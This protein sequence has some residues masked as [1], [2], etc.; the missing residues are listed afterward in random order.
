MM[1]ADIGMM[2]L[3]A[4]EHQELLANTRKEKEA[5]KCLPLETPEKAQPD[6]HLDWTHRIQKCETTDFGYFRTPTLWSFVM[7]VLENLYTQ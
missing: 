4:K 7:A 6:E 3:W 1:E 5:R 2:H